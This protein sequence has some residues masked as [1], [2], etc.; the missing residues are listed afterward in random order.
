MGFTHSQFRGT[1][2]SNL[3]PNFVGNLS[4]S[5]S[6]PSSE[7]SSPP[8]SPS[9]EA[10][11]ASSRLP[12][13]FATKLPAPDSSRGKITRRSDVYALGAILYHLVIGRPPFAAYRIHEVRQEAIHQ[14]R[15]AR[16]NQ[17]VADINL[18]AEALWTRQSPGRAKELLAGLD[19]MPIVEPAYDLPAV[20]EQRG[21]LGRNAVAFSPS[22]TQLAAGYSDRFCRARSR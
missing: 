2:V 11:S 1:L 6:H 8:L 4:E 12:T 10:E 9:A 20:R 5:L 15:Q 14:A 17:Y 19:T 21:W 13:K 7:P 16:L 18:A 22:G 3:V